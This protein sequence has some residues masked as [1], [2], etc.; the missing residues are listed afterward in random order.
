MAPSL[1]GAID[2]ITAQL[3]EKYRPEKIILFGSA[4]RGDAALDSDVDLLIIKS[5]TPPFSAD[6]IM[7]VSSLIERDVP[8]DFLV[9]RPEE[10][11]KRISLGDPFIGLILKEGKVLYG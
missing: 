7:E 11:E 1:Q 3:I 5:D 8:V 2:S 10:F 4:A 9:Y 6:G